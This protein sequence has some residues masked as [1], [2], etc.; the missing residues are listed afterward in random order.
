MTV[1]DDFSPELQAVIDRAMA[2]NPFARF[3]SCGEL[4][5]AA[6]AALEADGLVIPVPV[7]L[8]PR[9]SD[10]GEQH[11]AVSG[12]PSDHGARRPRRTVLLAAALALVAVLAVA[13]VVALDGSD[14]RAAYSA[15]WTT[16]RDAFD[17]E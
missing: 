6:R 16:S 12:P 14:E 7:G 1:R 17:A 8:P 15:S 4:A 11:P 2:K 13:A 10:H 9:P 3:T 5:A